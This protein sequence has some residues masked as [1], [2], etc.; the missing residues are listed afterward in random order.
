M[1]NVTYLQLSVNVPIIYFVN[2]NKHEIVYEFIDGLTAK[3]YIE[4]QR[5]SANPEKFEV[6]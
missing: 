6:C 1:I 3:D 5:K 4:E 2:S